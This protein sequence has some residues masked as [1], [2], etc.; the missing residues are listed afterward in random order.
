MALYSP[1]DIQ[2]KIVPTIDKIRAWIDTNPGGTASAC[3]TAVG[4]P[5]EAVYYAVEQIIGYE[6]LPTTSTEYHA[7]HGHSIP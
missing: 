5:V 3:A 2:A 1:A 4:C 6:D 7:R